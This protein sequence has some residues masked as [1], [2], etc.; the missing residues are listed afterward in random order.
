MNTYPALRADTLHIIC[1]FLQGAVCRETD[2]VD[3]KTN[4][5]DY[6]KTMLKLK[7]KADINRAGK[8]D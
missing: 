2:G 5:R 8:D 3:N 6:I 4:D 1:L 7:N